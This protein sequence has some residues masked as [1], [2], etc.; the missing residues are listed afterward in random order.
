MRRAGRCLRGQAAT[1]AAAC[2]H[3][4]RPALTQLQPLALLCQRPA[5]SALPLTASVT[6]RAAATSQGLLS[7]TFDDDGNIDVAFLEAEIGHLAVVRDGVLRRSSKEQVRLSAPLLPSSYGSPETALEGILQ[8]APLLAGAPSSF[9]FVG[10]GGF[11]ARTGGSQTAVAGS[12]VRTPA[13][14]LN[15]SSSQQM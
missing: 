6:A 7:F 11:S 12:W 3:Y 5:D 1:Q 15:G 9:A 13:T 4:H 2:Y 8:H 10:A 14:T